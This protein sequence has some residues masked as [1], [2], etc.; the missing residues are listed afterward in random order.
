MNDADYPFGTAQVGEFV[1]LQLYKEDL[2]ESPDAPLP[3]R[4][5]DALID[6][7]RF[8]VD[9]VHAELELGDSLTELV[10]MMRSAEKPHAVEVSIQRAGK[11][12][13]EKSLIQRC[14][15]SD[16]IVGKAFSTTQRTFVCVR[17]TP[18]P[19]QLGEA[20]ELRAE[21][22]QIHLRHTLESVNWIKQ[23]GEALSYAGGQSELDGYRRAA[24]E[25]RHHEEKQRDDWK[26]LSWFDNL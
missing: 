2:P 26:W 4:F 25:W 5:W 14:Y 21:A 3:L 20:T 9:V 15:V 6:A 7:A 11:K 18:T 19:Q 24:S 8:E 16:S 1:E 23:R 12:L 22:K 13:Q 10:S 17:I